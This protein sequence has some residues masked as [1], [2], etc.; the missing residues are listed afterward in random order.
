MAYIFKKVVFLTENLRFRQM[1]SPNYSNTRKDRPC[2]MGINPFNAYEMGEQR[3]MD[4]KNSF[5]E[6]RK[7]MIGPHMT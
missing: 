6:N 5:Q 7:G 1:H 3:S 4:T 2:L